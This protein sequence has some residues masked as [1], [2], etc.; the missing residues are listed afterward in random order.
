VTEWG[1]YQPG[2]RPLLVLYLHGSGSHQDQGMKTGIYN[3]LFGR[4][5]QWMSAQRRAVYICPEYRGNS[6]MGP[7]AE[8]DVVEI[9]RLARERYHPARVLLTGGSMGGTSALIFASRHPDLLDGVLALCPATDPAAMYPRFAE[10]FRIGYGGSPTEK[11][12][13]YR[14][15]TSRDHAD[16]LTKLP[17]AIVHGSADTVIPVEHSRVLVERLKARGAPIRYVELQGA[18]HDGPC[19][20][21]VTA[22][23]DWLVA[24]R[25]LSTAQ[26]VSNSRK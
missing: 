9:L 7:A 10:Q 13:V 20:A 24:E 21:D 12:G 5:G 1:A 25:P 17:V 11:A 6:W 26:D 14:D 2:E 15:R 16:A 8:A 19:K 4:M 3:D 22:L 23:L 18:D